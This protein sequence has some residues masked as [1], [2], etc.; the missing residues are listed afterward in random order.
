VSSN[1]ARSRSKS[2]GKFSLPPSVKRA[3]K[4]G[5]VLSRVPTS[6]I[7]LMPDFIIIGAQRCG[8]TSLYNYLIS[9]PCIAP[10]LWKEVHFF[11]INYERG[12]AWYRA[13]FPTSLYKYY[14]EQVRKRALVIGE[15]SPYYIFHPLAPRR[16]FEMIPEVR[17]IALLRNPVDR[18]F[19]HHRREARKGFETLSFEDAIQREEERLR[20]GADTMFQNEN[21]YSFNHQHYSYL[22]RGVYVDQLKAWMSFFSRERILILKSEDFF[23]DPSATLRQV[24]EFLNLPDWESKKYKK[25]GYTHEAEMDIRIREY[26]VDY[27]RPHNRRLYEYLGRDFGWDRGEL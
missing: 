11:D 3:V 26:L 14:V 7:R 8:T 17:L 27:F 22:F 2:I 25:Y 23:D 6:Q 21:Y 19:S 12:S 5:L 4:Q 1:R 10:A 16:V 18:A 9:H 13:H 15:S 24:V 20:G